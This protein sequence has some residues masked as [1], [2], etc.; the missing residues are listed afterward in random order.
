MDKQ[1]YTCIHWQG[2]K[3]LVADKME[4]YP[5]CMDRKNGWPEAGRCAISSEWSDIYISGDATAKFETN[6][7]FGC[8]YW[9]QEL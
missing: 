5:M 1:C 2:N 7:N 8:N 6:A 3:K 9:E 4:K